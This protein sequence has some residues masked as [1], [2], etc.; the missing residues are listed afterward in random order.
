MVFPPSD[1][2]PK[3]ARM[4]TPEEADLLHWLLAER[5]WHS[6]QCKAKRQAEL[7]AEE[8]QLHAQ[9]VASFDALRAAHTL[10]VEQAAG[11]RRHLLEEHEPNFDRS[12][13]GKPISVCHTCYGGDYDVNFPCDV[14]VLARDWEDIND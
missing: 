7:R 10:L 5:E 3:T 11:L 1:D 9:A 2:G 14:Y 4:C 13:R 12:Y 8:K 6:E